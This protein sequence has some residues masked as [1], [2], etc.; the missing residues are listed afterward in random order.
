[1]NRR[2]RQLAAALILCYAA[3]FVTLNYWQVGRKEELDASFDNTRAI[4]REFE[5]PRGQIVTTDGTVIATSVATPPGS[6]FKYQ[7]QYPTGDLYG[8]I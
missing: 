8:D 1:M 6:T 3:L 2:I 5:K 4:K 7:R